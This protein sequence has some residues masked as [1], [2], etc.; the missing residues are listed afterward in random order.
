MGIKIS[1]LNELEV[2]NG[3]EMF[4]VATAGTNKR[5]SL[6]T[7]KNLVSNI[8]A[9]DIGLGNVD[10]TSD[11][12][13]PLSIAAI[14]ALANKAD[15]DHTHEISNIT[16]LEEKLLEK[17]EAT[18][19]HTIN[20]VAGL[21]EALEARS[22]VGHTHT[23]EDVEGWDT[24][25][26]AIHT[27]TTTDITDLLDV[28]DNEIDTKIGEA[29]IRLDQVDTLI[30][31][32]SSKAESVHTH[33]SS[34][35][36]DLQ[37]LLDSK[38]NIDHFHEIS[39]VNGLTALLED[40]ASK[41]HTHSTEQVE[42]LIDLLNQK[43]NATHQHGV[44]DV[45][46]LLE[47]LN[48]KVNTTDLNV[49]LASKANVEHQHQLTDVVGLSA[50]LAQLQQEILRV[51]ESGGGASSERLDALEEALA[52]RPDRDSVNALIEGSIGGIRTTV[53]G[54][55]SELAETTGRSNINAGAIDDIRNG[56]V[57]GTTAIIG[58]ENALNNRLEVTVTEW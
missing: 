19:E 39:S 23:G 6:Q 25:A 3:N 5:V 43:A 54:M 34:D 40:K 57:L 2:L 7:I 47:L 12:D 8:S 17:A 32:L 50:N 28:V 38:S 41:E 51:Q 42:G 35:I 48:D 10:N 56:N 11:N 52:Q 49:H 14:E 13:K 18:H 37:A 22:H 36:T 29:T 45:N 33:T 16:G 1:Q 26:D 21:E 15:V 55:F 4:I 46:G 53:D 20:Q 31:T 44:Q 24:K 27:H 58:L 30:E 9:A